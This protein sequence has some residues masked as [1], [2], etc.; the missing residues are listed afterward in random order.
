MV[1]LAAVL[2]AFQ[3]NGK[4]YGQTTTKHVPHGRLETLQGY[5]ILTLEGTPQQMGTA[6][7]RLLGKTIHRVLGDMITEG[8]AAQPD[9]YANLQAGSRVM[10]R[11]QPDDYIVEIKAL[12]RAAGVK[13]EDLLLLQ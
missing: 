12:A 11:H 8:I 9:A 6:H 5:K 4:I 13:D 2:L 7:G 3:P 1:V 10:A